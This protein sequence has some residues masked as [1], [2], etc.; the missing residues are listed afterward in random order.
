MK[1][2]AKGW[3]PG[4]HRPMASGD[5]L[6][7]RLRPA[8]GRMTAADVLRVCTVAGAC[9]NGM[10]ELTS[11]ANLQLRG[12]S[13]ASHPE[14][15][16]AL[17]GLI[18]ADPA[19]ESR[20]NIL[21]APLWQAGDVTQR[22]ATDLAASLARL[23]DLPA[24][25]G[26]AIDAGP[27]PVLAGASADIRLEHGRTGRLIVRADGAA[28]G[29]PVTP[30]T[31]LDAL[32][33]LAAWFGAAGGAEAGRMARLLAAGIAPPG[34]TEPAAPPAPPLPPGLSPLG[35]LVGAPFGQ[36][37]AAALARLV[38]ASGAAA[39]RF[40]PWRLLL[41]EGGQAVAAP[42]FVTAPGD[43][44]LAAAA[45]PGAP[46]CSAASVETRALARA[47]APAVAGSLHVSGCAKGCARPAA[48]DLTLVGHGGHF[49]IVRSG[50]AWAMPAESG[51]TA[52][53]ILARFGGP[54]AP[55]L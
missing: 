28:A 27:S 38:R 47:L 9:G 55:R 21:V 49:D 33:A 5:G 50:P 29:Q 32:L 26:F 17:D 20:R 6:V 2:A 35:P 22:I 41:L 8:L 34:A 4:S 3:C 42:E 25:F 52:A 12:L 7:L 14:A 18:D 45:C 44:V 40:T 43:P 36:M 10:L 1:P 16:A 19:L 31:A 11:R 51:L 23:P 39:L 53:D 30:D 24:K 37:T 15:L 48:A 54:D 13:P 46:F